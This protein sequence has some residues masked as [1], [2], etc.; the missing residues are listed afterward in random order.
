ML[1]LGHGVQGQRDGAAWGRNVE[2]LTMPPVVAGDK[3]IVALVAIHDTDHNYIGMEAY[4]DYTV[5]WGDGSAPENFLEGVDATHDY[6]YTDADLYGTEIGRKDAVACTFQGT[7]DTV[8][9]TAHGWLDGQRVM[10]TQVNTTTGIS[11]NIRYFVR[12]AAANTFKLAATIDG[13]AIDL[14]GDGT[15]MVFAPGY[16]QAIV[17][18][19]PQDTGDWWYWDG[20][21]V[22]TGA[23]DYGASLYL[24]IVAAGSDLAYIFHSIP[25]LRLNAY[26]LERVRILSHNLLSLYFGY[27]CSSLKVVEIE[28]MGKRP[29][30]AA[31]YS[32]VGADNLK[33]F[34]VIDIGSSTDISTMFSGCSS[35]SEVPLFDTSGVTTAPDMFYAC[36]SLR[37][38]PKFDFSNVT[39]FGSNFATFCRSLQEVEATG[40]SANINFTSCAMSAD[41][42]NR[43][44][45]NL[46]TVVGKTI[47]VTG[48]PG[49]AT[50]NTA[51]ATGKGWTVVT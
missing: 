41:A 7:G 26:L 30:T 44:F 27:S 32:F 42:L 47:T 2:W 5:D 15:G 11:A 19:T 16:R 37:K 24:D 4:G 33:E 46:E 8:T 29:A 22:P 36:A 39:N 34:P 51:I 45:T 43:L 31:S 9:L 25:G 50:C 1:G 6:S 38:I 40:I 13:A 14:V 35:A 3:K 28:D 18:V 12:D 10:F 20:G 21:L 17:T 23:V 49:A 48:N